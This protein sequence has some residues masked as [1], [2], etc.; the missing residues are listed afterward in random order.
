MILIT[1]RRLLVIAA[2]IGF[3][4]LAAQ[5]Q[6]V[7]TLLGK[8]TIVRFL[9]FKVNAFFLPLVTRSTIDDYLESHKV[10]KLQIGC[11]GELLEGWLNT[12]ISLDDG[13]AY[14]DATERFPFDDQSFHYVFSEH[15]IE[16]LPYEGGQRMLRS[17]YR[18]LV[19]GG[20]IRIATPNLDR[21]A[22]LFQEQ[23]TEEMKR[24]LDRKIEKFGWPKYPSPECFVMNLQ[25]RSWG[26]VFLYDPE[27]LTSVMK[28][29]GFRDIRQVEIGESD[30]IHL[31]DLEFRRGDTDRFETMVLEAT[32]PAN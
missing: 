14:L 24:F 15:V 1:R 4:F 28:R 2:V 32:K 26:H 29:T 9:H 19:P 20:K 11:G 22:S 13:V 27:T 23:K 7:R 31:R 25:M 12:D 17:S 16:H 8:S 18:I 21:F 3:P 30:D 5:A 6:P 10:R